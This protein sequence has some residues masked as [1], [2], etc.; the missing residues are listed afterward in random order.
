MQELSG[1]VVL[2]EAFAEPGSERPGE[3]RRPVG[4]HRH[5][6]PQHGD[7][8]SGPLATPAIGHRL[9]GG[10]LAGVDEVDVGSQD[11][12][13]G[14]RNR[15]VRPGAVD[16]RR[17][18]EHEVV[19]VARDRLGERPVDP[20]GDVLAPPRPGVRIARPEVDDDVDRPARRGQGDRRIGLEGGQDTAPEAALGPAD[21]HGDR[22]GVPRHGHTHAR[23]TVRCHCVPRPRRPCACARL[24]AGRAAF[25]PRI[26]RAT[27]AFVGSRSVAIAFRARRSW[28]QPR[29][30]RS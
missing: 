22:V 24:A 6:R 2:A 17:G 25:G 19:G 21:R 26:G 15:V 7:G 10:Q 1:R 12:V 30:D 23:P 13:L 20:L 4:G 3:V 5:D 9:G 27:A 14:E 16:H 11:G 29:G 8:A 28:H 18:D